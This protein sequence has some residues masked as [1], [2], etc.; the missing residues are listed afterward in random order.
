AL[1]RG[2]DTAPRHGSARDRRSAAPRESRRLRHLVTRLHG[3]LGTL[4]AGARSLLTL[5]AGLHGPARSAAATARILHVSTRREARLERLALVAL[6][7]SA[8]TGC[9]GPA[10]VVTKALASAGTLGTLPPWASSPSAT[11]SASVSASASAPSASLSDIHARRAPRGGRSLGT[12][13]AGGA[14]TVQRAETPGSSFPSVLIPALLALVLALALLALPETRRRLRPARADSPTASAPPGAG[15]TDRPRGPGKNPP[16]TPM[17]SPPG[18][19]PRTGVPR[20]PRITGRP[21]TR[22]AEGMAQMA[23]DVFAAMAG[24]PLGAAPQSELEP[25]SQAQAERE[26][27]A[28]GEPA[29]D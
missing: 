3:C 18:G 25:E 26:P 6:R 5:R 13:A 22:M 2:R 29:S 28:D 17:A 23:T 14:G 24:E 15:T 19:A 11:P 8:G 9:A 20:A 27:M 16:A 7:R 1:A 21:A 4:G 12:I 10:T